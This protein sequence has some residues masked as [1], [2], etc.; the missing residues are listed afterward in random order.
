MQ[1][2]QVGIPVDVLH[3]AAASAW[4]GGLVMVS[5]FGLALRRKRVLVDVMQRFARLAMLA[6]TVLVT[7]GIVQGLRLTGSPQRALTNGH[8][9]Y[10][11]LKLAVIAVMLKI[12]DINRRRV[13]A[14]V[15]H[16]RNV[17]RSSVFALRRAMANRVR[18]R[19]SS[20]R[21][22]RHGHHAAAGR[23][24]IAAAINRHADCGRCPES[25]ARALSY[26]LR[27]VVAFRRPIPEGPTCQRGYSGCYLL[28]P[29]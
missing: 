24:P 8:G 17:T 15:S 18:R 7:T 22:H 28:D 25:D 2:P 23:A 1:W 13:I 19:I 3:H 11:L 14:R 27:C 6:V 20:D 12:A 26:P 4:L 21:S 5:Q 16:P 29:R 9:R 10:L